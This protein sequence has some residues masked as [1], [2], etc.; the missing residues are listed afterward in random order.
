MSARPKV[1][2]TGAGGFVGGRF[3]E[4]FHAW[5]V[6]EVRAGLRRWSSGARVGRT[7]VELVLCDVTR[8]ESVRAALEGVDLVVH[9]AVGGRDATVT[10]TRT[11][12]DESLR[13]GVKRVVHI[14]TIDVYGSTDGE[15]REDAALT[16]TGREYG[17]TKI[18]AEEACREYLQR[19]LAV[20]MLR[21]TLVHGPFSALWSVEIAGRVQQRPFPLPET[22]C[23]GTCNLVYVDDVVLAG[24]LALERPEA[25]GEAFNVGGP[26][27]PTWNAYF[28]A[29]N[30]AL[31]LPPLAR[32]A[33]G[34]SRATSLLVHPVRMAAKFGMKQF[35][36]QIMTVYQ[37]SAAAKNLMKRAE[38][39]I[40]GTP[41][42]DEFSYYGRRGTYPIDKARRLLGY[43]PAFD[44]AR[45]LPLTAAW[46]RAHGYIG[47]PS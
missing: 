23:G 39:L 20:S 24:K 43:A 18:E 14:S 30:T 4:L 33:E 12:L 47:T 22:V 8:A 45:S 42:L 26:E 21:P 38:K 11:L 17:D 10:G 9:C 15:C 13:A 16:K 1:L 3:A 46:L 6:G 28:E 19:G 40:R 2:I 29:L 27:V 25:V 5:G 31:G 36:K 34:G 35:E 7:P 41:G 44:M 37:S 32:Q